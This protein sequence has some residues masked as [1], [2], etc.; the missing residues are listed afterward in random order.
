VPQSDLDTP[1]DGARGKRAGQP[2][3]LPQE[4]RQ[5]IYDDHLAGKSLSQIARDLDC[6]G[7]ATAKGGKW[8]PYTVSQVIESVKLDQELAAIAAREF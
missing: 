6:E 3:V 2:P 7:V 8:H 5:R 1:S 4:I